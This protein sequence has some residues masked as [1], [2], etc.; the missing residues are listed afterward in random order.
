MLALSNNPNKIFSK[1]IVLKYNLGAYSTTQKAISTFINEGIIEN[2]NNRYEFSD[3][4][5]KLFLIRNL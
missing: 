2:I 5:F 4:I 1:E 3:P